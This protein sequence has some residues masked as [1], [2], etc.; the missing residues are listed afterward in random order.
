MIGECGGFEKKNNA[1]RTLVRQTDRKRT[2]ARHRHNT[3]W[4]GGRGMDS[5]G[6]GKD[7]LLMR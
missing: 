1:Y 4:R 2:H 7:N 5:L 6:Q 3:I